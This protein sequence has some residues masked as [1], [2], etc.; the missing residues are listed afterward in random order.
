[1]REVKKKYLLLL[2]EKKNLNLISFIT[3]HR[4]HCSLPNSI[5][6]LKYAKTMNMAFFSSLLSANYVLVYF[7]NEGFSLF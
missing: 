2:C 1:M 5:A 7:D 6:L 3:S 4:Q